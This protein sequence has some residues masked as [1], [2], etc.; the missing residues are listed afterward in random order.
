MVLNGRPPVK[1]MKRRVTADLCDFLTF[2]DAGEGFSAA[3]SHDQ[4]FR[5]ILPSFLSRH[6]R[7][8][9]SHER[10]LLTWQI[11]YWM[12]DLDGRESSPETLA[13]LHVV[14][15]DVMKSGSDYCDMC[16]VVGESRPDSIATRRVISMH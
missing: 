12:G 15:E 8:V 3:G 4:P 14:E 11:A 1:R 2:S 13:V 10:D 5:S 7:E 6:A 9:P 16:R